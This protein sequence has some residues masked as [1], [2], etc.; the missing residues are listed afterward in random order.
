MESLGSIPHAIGDLE[1]L[2]AL[3]ENAPGRP[4]L[5]VPAMG[6]PSGYYAPFVEAVAAAGLTTGVVT[7]PQVPRGHRGRYPAGD[8]Y[9]ALEEHVVA[10]AIDVVRT[11]GDG[12]DPV[13][14]GHSLGGHLSAALL[15]RHPGAAAGLVLVASGSPHWRSYGRRVAPILVQTQLAAAISQVLGYWPGDRLGFGGRQTR[16]TIADWARMARRG[17]LVAGLDRA[18]GLAP[19]DLPVLAVDVEGDRYTPPPSVD[20][21]LRLMP[22]ARVTRHHHGEA[23]APGHTRW[24]RD[25][26]DLPR[27]IAT[28]IRAEVDERGGERA[29]DDA[30]HPDLALGR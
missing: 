12:R 1:V 28:W 4:V 22:G 7:L 27:R 21:L 9:A 24:A 30:A 17:G 15:S 11:L 29:G 18:P 8:G 20:A 2:G 13:L 5:V 23:S 6:V 3:P 16:A 26:E 14:V 19:L 25:P 10:P